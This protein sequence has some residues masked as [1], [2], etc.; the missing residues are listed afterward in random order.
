MPR[1]RSRPCTGAQARGFARM[2][3]D[4]Q[5]SVTVEAAVAVS[6]LVLVFSLIVGGLVTLARYLSAVD[7][8][9]AAARSHAIGTDYPVDELR[10]VEILEAEGIVTA[11]VRVRTPVGKLEAVARYPKEYS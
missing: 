3:G 11:T 1:Q 8:A 5:G 9:G 4:N 2:G 7:T 6:C 10:S